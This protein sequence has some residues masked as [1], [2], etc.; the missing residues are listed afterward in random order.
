MTITMIFT[1][2]F[3]A[4]MF[5]TTTIYILFNTEVEWICTVCVKIGLCTLYSRD[6]NEWQVASMHSVPVVLLSPAQLYEPRIESMFTLGESGL[7]RDDS[8]ETTVQPSFHY[9]HTVYMYVVSVYDVHITAFRS[10]AIR[11]SCIQT[12]DSYNTVNARCILP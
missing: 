9:L 6:M 4:K 1:W 8:F 5:C 2:L 11:V 7:I 12:V 10:I 3:H